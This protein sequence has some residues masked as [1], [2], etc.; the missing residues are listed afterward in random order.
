M[1]NEE[2]NPSGADSFEQRLQRQPMREIPPEWRTEI[3]AAANPAPRVSLWEAFLSTFNF[4]PSTSLRWAGL[5][6]IWV[7]IFALH[8]SA[9]DTSPVIEAKYAPPS[10]QMILALREQKELLAGLE[11]PG[12]APQADQPKPVRPG[13][14]SERR[15]QCMNG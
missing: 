7:V 11:Q 6:A 12:E 15:P 13:P 2:N 1:K 10:P 3:L 9:R 4:Q 14:H 5:A 8:H